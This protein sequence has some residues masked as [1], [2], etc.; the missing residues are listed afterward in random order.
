MY[1]GGLKSFRPNND[2]RHFFFILFF[3]FLHSL[4]VTL[5]TSPSDAPISLTHQNSTRHFSLQNNF[6]RIVLPHLKKTSMLRGQF[7][8]EG[9]KRNRLGLDLV[10]MADGQAV[11]T[12]IHR[13]SP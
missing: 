8:D 7:L 6:S 9:T 10:S 4:L 12:V 2:T 5:H 1:E 11:Q 3:I 13:F